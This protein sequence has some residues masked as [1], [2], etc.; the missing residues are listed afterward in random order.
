MTQKIKKKTWYK[1]LLNF[2]NKLILI[3]FLVFLLYNVYFI[4]FNITSNNYKNTEN[5]FGINFL[6][7]GY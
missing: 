4:I 3:N 1:F 6:F 2:E 5:K 7:Y